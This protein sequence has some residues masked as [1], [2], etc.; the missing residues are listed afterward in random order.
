MENSKNQLLGK[1]SLYLSFGL[2]IMFIIVV[3]IFFPR[4]TRDRLMIFDLS[5]NYTQA[6]LLSFPSEIGSIQ[7][8][9]PSNDSRFELSTFPIYIIL[10]HD[11]KEIKFVTDKKQKLAEYY[12]SLE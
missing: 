8:S 3:I 1:I 11:S 12:Q 6:D 10:S 2:I 5:S 9:Y 7:F 4:D